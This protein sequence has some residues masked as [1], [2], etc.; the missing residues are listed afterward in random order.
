MEKQ[1]FDKIQ[2][3]IILKASIK[4]VVDS[5]RFTGSIF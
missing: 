2:N 5:N 4:F 1:V 3:K